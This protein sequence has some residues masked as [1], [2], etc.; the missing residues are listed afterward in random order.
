[1]TVLALALTHRTACLADLEKVTVPKDEVV[2][3]TMR[4]SG[5]PALAEVVALPTCNRTEVYA[6]STD[7]EAGAGEIRGLLEDV[8]ALPP[9]WA[10]ERSE[11][12]VGADAV[13]HLFLVASGLDSMVPGEM[14]IQG[15]VREAFGVGRDAGTVG[16]N[17]DVLFRRALLAGKRARTSSSLAE[18]RRSVSSAAAV[19]MQELLGDLRGK[20]IIVIGTGKM[21]ALSIPVLSDHGAQ[22]SVVT[23]RAQVAEDLAVELGVTALA[24]EDLPRALVTADAALFVTI[25]PHYVLTKDAGEAI[26]AA[27][28]GG[29][30][31]LA[32]DLGMPR[33]VAPD[34][35]GTE[36]ID[37]YDLE[38]LAAEGFT[39]ARGWERELERAE[40]IAVEEAEACVGV[41]RSRS[42]HDVVV[43]LHD[44]AGK[45]V[46]VE[47]QRALRKMPDLGEDGRAAVEESVRR[48]VQKLVHTPTVR[49]KEAASRGDD[50]ILNAARWLFGVPEDSRLSDATREGT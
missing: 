43:T 22:V 15:Q 12:L 11:V 23:K 37:L 49:A 17:L 34:L 50:G 38:R 42:A 33:N 16:P 19:A 25:A 13:R 29:V 45:V 7:T 41:L 3:L 36:G 24:H 32:I 39:A 46:A 14:Q 35:D 5:L 44:L 26:A 8:N 4:L 21:A 28:R 18:A 27:R 9:G 40:A 2:A 1:M 10:R 48:A 20:R 6:W 47:V 31:L 30:P